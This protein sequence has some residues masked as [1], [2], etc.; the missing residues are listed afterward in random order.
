MPDIEIHRRFC[1][2]PTSGNG[3]YTAGLL[4]RH[5]DGPATVTLRRPPPLERPLR[6]VGESG[7]VRLLDGE[8]VIAEAVPARARAR[9]AVGARHDAA[10][11]AGGGPDWYP[12]PPVPGCFVCGPDRADGLRI[13][14]GP[15]DGT[16]A[17]AWTPTPEFADDRGHVL[18]EIVWSALDCPSFAPSRGLPDPPIAMVLGRLTAELRAPVTAGQTYV[19]VAWPIARDGRKLDTGSALADADGRVVAVARARWIEI[20]HPT[21]RVTASPPRAWSLPPR[22]CVNRAACVLGNK[23]RRTVVLPEPRSSSVRCCTRRG[24]RSVEAVEHR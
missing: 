19:V 12:R 10:A 24:G 4:A 9:A 21:A 20:P 17:T 1:G 16:Y 2:P 11:A 3:G 7:G 13:F 18:G 6:A 15:L 5:I 23:E 8:D 14:P 22:G